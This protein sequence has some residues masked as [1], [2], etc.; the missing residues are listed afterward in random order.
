LLWGGV[1]FMQKNSYNNHYYLLWLLSVIMIF[2]PA[3]KDLSIDVKKGFTTQVSVMPNWVPILI[4]G[5]LAIVYTYASVAKMY[6]DWLNAT[7][8]K[9]LMA[10]RANYPI[11]GGLLQ[12]AWVHYIIVYVGILFDLLIIPA[13]LWKP[14]RKIAFALAVFFHLYNSVVFQIGI[15]P[16]LALGFTVFFFPAEKI[17]QWFYP[18][19]KKKVVFQVD[20]FLN[21]SLIMILVSVWLFIQFALPLRHWFIEGDVLWTEEGHRMSWR[22]MLR[23]K[24]GYNTFRVKNTATG[25]VKRV[26]LEEHL[27]P[28]QI[29]AMVGKPDIIWQFAQYLKKINYNQG[30]KVQVFANSW[31]SVNGSKRHRLV[32]PDID[33]AQEP[34][35]WWKHNCWVLLPSEYIN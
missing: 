23:S 25:V 1:Y 15:F 11:V 12:E 3:N 32:D 9:R 17:R 18:K 28:K 2:L 33:L 27:S 34:W 4:I 21:S 30:N 16:Y 29:R 14:S 13:L 19:K 35:T 24:S 26:K 20:T 10:G 6:P 22:M 7:V 8:P 5:Q 31:A